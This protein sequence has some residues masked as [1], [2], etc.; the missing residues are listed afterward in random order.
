MTDWSTLNLFHNCAFS[1]TGHPRDGM[2]DGDGQDPDGGDHAAGRLRLR[3]VG[4][5]PKA[6]HGEL[7][8]AEERPQGVL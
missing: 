1:T 8:A 4:R 2:D 3:G 7:D 5:P 6:A